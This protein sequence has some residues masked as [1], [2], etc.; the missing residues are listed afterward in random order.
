MMRII[1]LFLCTLLTYT[2]YSQGT[3]ATGVTLT[4][5]VQQC[6]DSAGQTG[7]FDGAGGAPTNPCDANYN[8]DEYWFEYT[9]AV[10]GETVDLTLSAIGDEWAGLFVLDDCPVNGPTCVA[11]AENGGSTADI[12][13]STG[14]LVAGTSYKIVITSWG[15]PNSTTFCLDAVVNTPTGCMITALA[16]GSQSPCNTV[17]N[18]YTQEVIVTYTSPPGAGTLDVNGQSFAIGTSPQTV[19]LTGL[20]SD[21]ADVDVTAVFSDDA[22]C[23]FTSLALFTAPSPCQTGSS[24]TAAEPLTVGTQQCGNSAGFAGDFP[25]AGGAPNNPCN[26]NYNDDEYWFSYTPSAPGITLEL[27]ASMLDMTWAGIFILDDCPVNGPTCVAGAENTSSTADL[28]VSAAVAMGTNYKIVI[29]SWGTPDNTA[30]CLDAVELTCVAPTIIIP[31]DPIDNTN[32]PATVDV[33][34]DITDLGNSAMVTVSAEDDMGNPAGTGGVTGLGIF[35]ITNIPV[36]QTSWTILIAHETDPSCDVTLGPFLLNCPPLNDNACDAEA[37]I[38][39]APQI[40]GTNLYSSFETNEVPGS[41]WA[42]TTTGNS[43]WYTFVA[44]GSGMV[45][46]TTDFATG[47]TD[48]QISLYDVSNCADLTTATEMGCSEDD[49]I[50]GSGWMSVIETS[51][52]PLTGGMTYYVQV[53]GYASQVG[54]FEIQVKELA[55]ANDD[56]ATAA[57]LAMNTTGSLINQYFQAAIPS[58]L[59]AELCDGASTPTPNDIWYSVNTDTD[60]GDLIINVEPGP[61]SDVVVAVY[62]MCGDPVANAEACVD[63]G[64]NG[65]TETVNF[66][67]LFKDKKGNESSSR[68]ADYFVR[69]YEKVKS[70]EP[71]E[72]GAQGDALPIVLAS[73]EAKAEK[74]GNLVQWSTELEINSDYVEVQSSPNGSTKWETVGKVA[75]KGESSSRIDYELFDNN[76]YE[77]TYYRLNAVD[78]DGKAELSRII[79]VKRSDNLGKM[80]LSP[81]PTNSSISL[82]TVSSTEE[83]G[84]VS[85][86]EL[87]GKI[88]KKESISLRKGLNTFS[89]ELDDLNAGIYLFSL[90]TE[91]G[92]QVEK[93]V[94]Q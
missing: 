40:P 5:G 71:F 85:V 55:P 67:A 56:C 15:T 79:N 27:T 84:T 37:I 31:A 62:N 68:D 53:D 81:N 76:P 70:G 47:L 73:F 90:Q 38:V 63:L 57:V 93:I 75:T 12:L 35:T 43:V 54:D 77:V 14:A 32:C 18:T 41:C 66:A 26:A 50:T 29:T 91:D 4:P 45:E 82:Q 22:L 61:N 52:A 3:C 21:G 42:V 65:S 24:C 44:P 13:L 64:G 88:M 25:N 51:G 8:D 83:M 59:G 36:P 20:N 87:T 80:S 10:N 78:K 89:I 30:F 92:I 23:T 6:G 69:V 49:G 11:S 2:T 1:L 48:S 17:D 16:A 9:A 72:I 60:G 7:D 34:I 94:K 46:V 28:V 74:R 19:T 58:G 86:F 33:D 39:D